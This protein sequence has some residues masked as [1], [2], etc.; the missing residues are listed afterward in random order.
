MQ[1]GNRK[2]MRPMAEDGRVQRQKS[3]GDPSN[4]LYTKVLG[5][6]KFFDFKRGYGFLVAKEIDEDSK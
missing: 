3:H 4:C 2:H 6:I 1:Y 5:K